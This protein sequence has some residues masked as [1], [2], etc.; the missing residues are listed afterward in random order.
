MPTGSQYQGLAFDTMSERRQLH[1]LCTS[2]YNSRIAEHKL[3]NN[4]LLLY[5]YPLRYYCTIDT[6]IKE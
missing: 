4:L 2:M 3:L 6:S 1:D 5:F